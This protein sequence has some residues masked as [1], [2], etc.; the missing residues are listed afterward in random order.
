MGRIT[1]FTRRAAIWLAL[2]ALVASCTSI[3]R[4]HGYV[5]SDEDLAAVTV[6]KSTQDEVAAAIGHPSSSGVLTGSG[7]YY[8]G[9]KFLHYG[10][11]APKEVERQVVAVS[12]DDK[13]VVENVERFGLENGKAVVISRRVTDSNIKGI[14]FLRQLLGNLGNISAGQVL[15]RN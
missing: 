8:V 6:G 4:N 12:F 14:G 7:W 13:G 3:Y 15:G 9:S 2:A 10:G 11:R 1:S 5:P